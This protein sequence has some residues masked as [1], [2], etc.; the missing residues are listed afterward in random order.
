MVK[1]NTS[2]YKYLRNDISIPCYSY[3]CKVKIN[4][5]FSNLCRASEYSEYIRPGI[6]STNKFI[7]PRY[8]CNVSLVLEE[9]HY[10]NVL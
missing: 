4:I 1:F 2:G 6:I 7:F 10:Q 8:K 9:L 3:I 5:K